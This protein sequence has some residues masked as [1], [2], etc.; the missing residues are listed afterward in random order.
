MDIEDF[1]SL[2][3]SDLGK[4]QEVTASS[5]VAPVPLGGVRGFEKSVERHHLY[6]LTELVPG[7]SQLG[8]VKIIQ[9]EGKECRG[10][11]PFQP[12]FLSTFSAAGWACDPI[13]SNQCPSLGF[14]YGL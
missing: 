7:S 6:L 11:P 2:C 4:D 13:R 14:L 9:A 10:Q 12:A 5:G 8:V 3:G 1:S